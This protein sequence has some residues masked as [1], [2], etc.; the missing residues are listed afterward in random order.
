MPAQFFLFGLVLANAVIES[1]N[2]SVTP[3]VK[4]YV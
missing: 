2:Q 3:L 4:I 1:V